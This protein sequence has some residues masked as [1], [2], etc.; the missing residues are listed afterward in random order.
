MATERNPKHLTKTQLKA[1]RLK[2]APGQEP[3]GQY[4]SNRARVYRDLY[5]ADA[6]V[7]MREYRPPS[8]AQVKAL[9]IGRYIASTVE[10]QGCKD[11]FY[12][13]EMGNGGAVRYCSPCYEKSLKKE[14]SDCATSWVSLD[15]L[16]VDLETTGLGYD[17]E[18]IEIAILDKSGSILLETLIKPSSPI[19]EQATF[20]NGIT[21]DMVSGSPAFVDVVDQISGIIKGRRIVAHNSNFDYEMLCGEFRRCGKKELFPT[22]NWL[23]SMMLLCDLNNDRYPS[24]FDAMLISGVTPPEEGAPHRAKYDAECCRRIVLKFAGQ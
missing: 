3:V 22:G 12:P 7:P 19:P 21:N 20:V 16:F 2:L 18:V 17:A 1:L 4:W 6:A 23:C 8:E 13:Y 10:C 15:P 24:L 5:D 9:E 11:R 14:A